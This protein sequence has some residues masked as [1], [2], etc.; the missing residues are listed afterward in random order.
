MKE[1]T[2]E[3]ANMRLER[4]TPLIS[5]VGCSEGMGNTMSYNI[6][7]YCCTRRAKF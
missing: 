4:Y 5:T 7:Y 6:T 3:Q 2:N 1:Q